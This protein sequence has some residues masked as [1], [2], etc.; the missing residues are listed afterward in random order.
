MLVLVNRDAGIKTDV[1]LNH[2]VFYHFLGTEQSQDVLCWRDPDHPKYIYMPEVTED[3]KVCM[4]ALVFY[5]GAK[6]VVSTD[7]IEDN[8]SLMISAATCRST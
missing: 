8:P 2:E 4:L 1:N 3:G 7:S 6:R 5:F